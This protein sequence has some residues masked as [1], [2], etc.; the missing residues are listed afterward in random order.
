MYN[1]HF[2]EG[3]DFDHMLLVPTLETKSTDKAF[4]LRFNYSE[5]RELYDMVQWIGGQSLK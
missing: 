1:V 5:N 3:I 4:I 2:L